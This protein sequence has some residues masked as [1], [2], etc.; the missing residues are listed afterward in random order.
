MFG[1]RKRSFQKRL[2]VFSK[3][4][5][6]VLAPVCSYDILILLSRLGEIFKSADELRLGFRFGFFNRGNFFGHALSY[7]SSS[8]DASGF[9]SSSVLSSHLDD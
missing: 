5:S 6:E 3:D 1:K 9:R 7:E 4:G 8:W 2:S